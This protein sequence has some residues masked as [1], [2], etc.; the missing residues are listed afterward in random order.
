MWLRLMPTTDLKKQWTAREIKAMA[1]QSSAHLLPLLSP[2]GGYSYLRASDGVGMYRAGSSGGDTPSRP[3]AMQVD[4]VAFAFRT[5]EVWSVETALLAYDKDR[6]FYS[7]IEKAFIK[8]AEH[9]RAFLK[10]LDIGP[11]YRWKAGL[12]GVQGRHLGYPARPGHYWMG[13]GPLCAT[14]HIEAEGSLDSEQ[15]TLTALIPFFE[16]IFDECGSERPDYLPK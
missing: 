13:P 5:G 6:L 15:S 7:D 11:L 3:N 4:S 14:D 10:A 1:M 9:Y 16:K 8:G 12:I 2:S